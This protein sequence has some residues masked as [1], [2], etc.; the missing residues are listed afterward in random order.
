[1]LFKRIRKYHLI[2]CANQKYPYKSKRI[3]IFPITCIYLNNIKKLTIPD[4]EPGLFESFTFSKDIFLVIHS[5]PILGESGC[6]KGCVLNSCS[7]FPMGTHLLFKNLKHLL[8]A[9]IM[10]KITSYNPTGSTPLSENSTYG[11]ILLKKK[12]LFW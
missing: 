12:C 9:G 4:F 7:F 11:N 8:L 1:M 3:L 10:S 5:E 2:T 6:L